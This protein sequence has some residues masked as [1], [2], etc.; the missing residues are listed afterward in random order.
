MVSCRVSNGP[1]EDIIVEGIKLNVNSK[2]ILTTTKLALEY[3]LDEMLI[4]ETLDVDASEYIFIENNYREK[5]LDILPFTLSIKYHRGGICCNEHYIITYILDNHR[6]AS[7]NDGIEMELIDYL[8]GD[9]QIFN[10]KLI[11][12][13]GGTVSKKPEKVVKKDEIL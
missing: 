5:Q 3:K 7:S 6:I 13:S 12:L 4:L 2:Y 11:N 1:E 8:Y 10:N 9:K